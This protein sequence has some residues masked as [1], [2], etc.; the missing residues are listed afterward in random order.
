MEK[1]NLK[2]QEELIDDLF[3][4]Y[5]AHVAKKKTQATIDKIDNIFKT[6]DD[7][8]KE[9]KRKHKK[10]DTTHYANYKQVAKETKKD[11]KK[12]REVVKV[13]LATLAN[14][15]YKENKITKSLYNKMYNLSIGASRFPALDTA[16]R[17]LK[18]FKDSD[19]TVK[20][21]HFIQA[22]KEKKEAKKDFNTIYIKYKRYEEINKEIII[23]MKKLTRK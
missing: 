8:Q 16:Y 7:K 2:F 14:K 5:D 17:S 6:Y 12:K 19:T 13:K 22:V 15:L 1:K 11:E 23:K 4:K 21:S 3:R 20:K 9:K 10:Q 18:D